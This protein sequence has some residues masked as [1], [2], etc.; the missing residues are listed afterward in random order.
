M[1]AR[2]DTSTKSYKIAVEAL[3]AI[4][5]DQIK[6]GDR[7]NY[8]NMA[9]EAVAG[10]DS[11]MVLDSLYKNVMSRA[12][13]NF[14]KIPESMGD[15][16]KFTKYKTIA[17]SLTLL[18]RALNEYNVP[19]LDITQELHDNIIR[20]RED[21]VYGF[22]V[23]SQF[24]KTTYNSEVYAL[25][26]MINL[27]D[28]IY[29]DMLKSGAEGKQFTY[30]GYQDLILVQNVKKFNDMVK[31]GEW[32][33]MVTGIRK[34]AR[35]LLDVVFSDTNGD[36]SMA[37]MAANLK[38]PIGI[39]GIW[40]AAGYK[41]AA[42]TAGGSSVTMGQ[43]ASGMGT[44]VSKIWGSVPG[45]ILI[46]I[47]AIIGV[48]F[49]VRGLIAVFYKGAYA[50]RDVLDDN[51]RFLKYHMD[52]NNGGS[53]D[54]LEKQKAMYE[55]LSGLRDKIETKILKSDAEGRKEIKKQN[56]EELTTDIYDTPSN[57]TSANDD[58]SI[59]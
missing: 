14:G 54:S 44:V 1:N 30:K 56:S 10:P 16:T 47:V 20:C 15:L 53:Y 34:D 12:S 42:A 38:A 49:I 31:S 19:E 37:N 57:H 22:K 27:C 24:L 13:I 3:N 5:A 17:D 59:G 51:E 18:H 26:E 33:R 35:N 8:R 23:D 55:A 40:A 48:L 52:S 36:G 39:F 28:V 58:F 6:P 4:A 41:T 50:L 21:F 25:C 7:I 45:K 32:S 29:I 2:Y 9:L 11:G 43:V 46:V